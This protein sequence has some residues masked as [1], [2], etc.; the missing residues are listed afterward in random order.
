[1]NDNQLD[2]I[3][4]QIDEQNERLQRHINRHFM[5]VWAI[6]T[7]SVVISLIAMWRSGDSDSSTSTGTPAS[8]RVEPTLLRDIPGVKG[9]QGASPVDAETQTKSA[10]AAC[11]IGDVILSGGYV[12]GPPDMHLRILHSA[13]DGNS[14]TVVA[15]EDADTPD[16][17]AW[18][19]TATA[20]CAG[21]T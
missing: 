14:W 17:L 3:F 20:I 15:A 1:M 8:S 5:A 13:P 16:A 6:V 4:A 18:G 7:A 10:V 2:E 21:P 9:A 12:L 11:P 19:V